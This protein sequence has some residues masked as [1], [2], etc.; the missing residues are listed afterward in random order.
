M[1]RGLKIQV[2]V[3]L[4]LQGKLKQEVAETAFLVG[5]QI[6]QAIRRDA[7]V[8]V[9]QQIMWLF[10]ENAVLLYQTAELIIQTAAVVA[11]MRTMKK[12]QTP[13]VQK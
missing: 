1:Q 6:V 4:V 8:Q 5:L 12:S 3:W 9:V 13:V 2:P 10:L 11:A 7:H